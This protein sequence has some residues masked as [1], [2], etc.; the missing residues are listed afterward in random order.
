MDDL[1]VWLRAQI[2]AAEASART[3]EWNRPHGSRCGITADN[4]PECD[5]DYWKTV[6][7]QCEAH[8][9]VL[10]LAETVYVG[11]AAVRAVG[12]AYQHNPGYRE[13]W[14]P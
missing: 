1:V 14:K 9:M 13:E 4:L 5:C 6:L 2:A 11:Y 12:L 10:R 7:A 8:E 3:D